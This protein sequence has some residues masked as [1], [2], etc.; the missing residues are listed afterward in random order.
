MQPWNPPLLVSD[1]SSNPSHSRSS[2]SSV[3]ISQGDDG[4]C[5]NTAASSDSSG[6]SGSVLKEHDYIGLAEVSSMHQAA[7]SATGVEEALNL[8]ET[9]LRLG[10]GP[11]TESQT[12]LKMVPRAQDIDSSSDSKK[13]GF[14]D[15][16]SSQELIK[17]S[18]REKQPASDLQQRSLPSVWQGPSAEGTR[19][20]TRDFQSSQVVQ[21]F[22]GSRPS[23]VN[24]FTGA[25][26]MIHPSKNGVKRV[27]SEAMADAARFNAG[28][29]RPGLNG[30]IGAAMVLLQETEVANHQQTAFMNWAA[31]KPTVPA[32]WHGGHEQASST[33]GSLANNTPVGMAAPRA[34]KIV[35]AAWDSR[36]RSHD[37]SMTSEN[38]QHSV[39][40]DQDSASM[41]TP[42]SKGQVV[43]WPPIRS[44]RKNT[45]AAHPKPA[46]EEGDGQL[47][48]KVNM[49]GI[50]IGRKV[51]LKAHT[52]YEGLLL[53]LE[54]MFQPSNSGQATSQ[55]ATRRENFVNEAKPL[56]L[57]NGSEFVLTYEDK[58]GDWMM[59]GDV[60]WG[61]FVETVRRLRIMRGSE[62]TGLAPR[63]P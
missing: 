11:L 60:P 1:S 20:S 5:Q 12:P 45:L 62:A 38:P 27:Y 15:A 46:E 56:R 42:P 26:V 24:A 41:D 13:I 36:N 9:D 51:D 55:A 30:G 8:E 47:F 48:V 61:M 33:Y 2:A 7:V 25:R 22:E 52:C 63:A 19:I 28:E 4:S 49:D 32:S 23:V 43:G 6:Q 14:V 57:L 35:D 53:A 16:L 10:L 58:D 44:Y 17:D 50:T 31:R 54:D 37:P 34:E 21:D 18:Q 40:V 29:S 59:V 3:V 39:M